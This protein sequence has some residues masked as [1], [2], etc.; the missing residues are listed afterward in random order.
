MCQL[1]GSGS[2]SKTPAL[3]KAFVKSAGGYHGKSRREI[4]LWRINHT[5]K[6]VISF[7]MVH[8][9]KNILRL[10][11]INRNIELR[12]RGYM[13]F[14]I[15]WSYA[16]FCQPFVKC[17]TIHQ[18]LQRYHLRFVFY[19]NNLH[20]VYILINTSFPQ[21]QIT[22]FAFNR[23]FSLAVS[24][25]DWCKTNYLHVVIRFW[26]INLSL[27]IPIIEEN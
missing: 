23:Q 2:N 11:R 22:D 7:E 16:I 14:N 3:C 25:D 4:N 21:R 15:K 12:D 24:L 17:Q 26:C 13:M 1:F 27:P 10:V 18:L 20:L 9:M 8:L 6:I 5:C 19:C